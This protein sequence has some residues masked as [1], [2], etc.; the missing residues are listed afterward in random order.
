MNRRVEIAVEAKDVQLF[1]IFV[2]VSLPPGYLD[3]RI[4][5]IRRG[6]TYGQRK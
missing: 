5:L 2:F 6:R 3:D 4:Y 1:V